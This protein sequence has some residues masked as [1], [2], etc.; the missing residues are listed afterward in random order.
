M[1]FL[2][3]PAGLLTCTLL[4]F[5]SPAQAA[6]NR[7][8]AEELIGQ[9]CRDDQ[10][11]W[12]D[13]SVAA[14]DAEQNGDYITAILSQKRVVSR[15]CDHVLPWIELAELHVR[16]DRLPAAISYLQYALELDAD[17]VLLRLLG[18]G[19][20][21]SPHLEPLLDSGLYRDSELF[22]RIDGLLAPSRRRRAAARRLLERMPVGQRPPNPFVAR[23]SCPGERC[24]FGDWKVYRDTPIV[25]APEGDLVVGHARKDTTVRSL[26]GETRIYDP[27]A[28]LVVHPLTV[29]QGPRGQAGRSVVV[30]GGEIVFLLDYHAEGSMGIWY[31]GRYASAKVGNYVRDA[32]VE[33]ARDCWGEFIDGRGVRDWWFQVRLADGTEGWTNR[34]DNFQTLSDA[35]QKAI[36]GN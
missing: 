17:E 34:N 4:A 7:Q 22:Q 20:L 6:A 10:S 24:G 23:P 19:F 9:P 36:L 29:E 21:R 11:A 30:P 15:L 28:V 13:D 12:T 1:R 31:D 26:T 16:V 32:C 2:S 25:A 8:R 35:A 18:T 27:P 33:P 3:R 5:G 14:W